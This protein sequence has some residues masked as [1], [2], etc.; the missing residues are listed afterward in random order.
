MGKWR[1]YRHRRNWHRLYTSHPL[2]SME[3]DMSRTLAS[4]LAQYGIQSRCLR[5]SGRKRAEASR[6]VFEFGQVQS[7]KPE[8]VEQAMLDILDTFKAKSEVILI[9]FSLGF[10][11]RAISTLYPRLNEYFS[12]WVDLQELAGIVSGGRY[13]GMRDTLIAL[14]FEDDKQ[15]VRS[16]RSLDCAG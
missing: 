10:E 8:E 14:G 16:I 4:I 7:V 6:E 9:G 5:V 3:I 15:A 2:P 12:S 11:L 1:G 13:P